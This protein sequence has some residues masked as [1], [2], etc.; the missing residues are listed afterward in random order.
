[1]KTTVLLAALAFAAATPA[2]A[3]DY[4][5]T[6]TTAADENA[7]TVVCDNSGCHA[8]NRLLRN[9]VHGIGLFRHR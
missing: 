2:L 7:T 4:H 9:G 3:C 1:M 8:H 5:A 6:H